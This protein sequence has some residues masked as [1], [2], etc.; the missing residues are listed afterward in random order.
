LTN[1]DVQP[2]AYYLAG[3]QEYLKRA[4]ETSRALG[5][6]QTDSDKR[7]IIA[8]LNQSLSLANNAV[9]YY[10]DNPEGYLTRAELFETLSTLDPT[11][12]E[13]AAS[14]RALAARLG[15]TD[16]TPIAP[17]DLIEYAP[18]EEATL[19][20]RVAIALP[21][22]ET[23]SPITAEEASNTTKGTI[24]LL[25]GQT[26]ITVNSEEITADRLVYFTPKGNTQNETLTM[27]SKNT[28]APS[29]DCTPSFTLVL[30]SPLPHNLPVDWW[31][32]Q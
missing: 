27:K 23:S 5:L 21:G 30:S 18:L 1:P 2:L 9:L 10:P 13:K 4:R 7:K 28:C 3:S 6:N 29:P 15:K 12:T 8:F 31:I 25:A 32:V 17:S 20:D 11:A 16:R 26:E 22:D 14:D 19:L 24:T